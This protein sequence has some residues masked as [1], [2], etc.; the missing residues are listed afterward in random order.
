MHGLTN[1]KFILVHI[2]LFF[3]FLRSRIF[4]IIFTY[5]RMISLFSDPLGTLFKQQ[6]D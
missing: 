2:S 1:L 6:D 4:L 3:E 5:T